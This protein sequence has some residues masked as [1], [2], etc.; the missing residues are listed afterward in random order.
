MRSYE[1]LSRKRE[2]IATLG[3]SFRELNNSHSKWNEV[4]A[5][6]F[7]QKLDRLLIKTLY[8]VVNQIALRE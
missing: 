4:T 7:E 8:D 3:N 1:L 5:Q 6:F 2:Y